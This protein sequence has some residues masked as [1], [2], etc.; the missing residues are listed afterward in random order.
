MEYIPETTIAVCQSKDDRDRAFEEADDDDSPCI[1]V[2]EHRKYA[3][4]ECDML[5]SGCVLTDSA[6]EE[7]QR[8]QE[9]FAEKAYADADNKASPISR[10]SSNG[11]VSIDGLRISDAKEFAAE[12]EPIVTDSNNHER[13]GVPQPS[14]SS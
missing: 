14:S 7:V 9:Q 8:I 4:V 11:I 1:V 5:P 3:Y 12:I 13:R 6:V 2:K 10:G